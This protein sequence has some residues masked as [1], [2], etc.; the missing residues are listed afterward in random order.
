MKSP[1]KGRARP[2]GAVD[3]ASAYGREDGSLERRVEK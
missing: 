1:E 2:K 3:A